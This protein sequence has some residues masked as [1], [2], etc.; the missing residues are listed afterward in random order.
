[1]ARCL[2][3]LHPAGAVFEIR[4]PKT[5]RGPSRLRPGVYSGYYSDPQAAAVGIGRYTGA[6]AD[7][8]YVTLNQIDP[9]L[10]ARRANRFDYL[11]KGDTTTADTQV[12]RR[13]AFYVD[14]DPIRV[15]DV[16]STE[17]EL[18][19]ALA[20][21]TQLVAYLA[22]EG[23][24]DPRIAG[25]SGNGAGLIWAV[26]EPA[27]AET[28][29][30]FTQA[31]AALAAMFATSTVK[32]DTTVV[33]RARV[34]KLYGTVA[35]KGDHTPERPW[36]RAT[37][38][39]R[40]EAGVV[41]RSQLEALAAHAPAPPA[42]NSAAPAFVFPTSGTRAWSVAAKLTAAGIG[43]TGKIRDYGTVYVLDECLTSTAHTDGASIIE[44]PS[45]MLLYRCQHDSCADKRW[46]DAKAALGL[47]DRPAAALETAKLAEG[48][49]AA[50]TGPAEA[51][52]AALRF[53]T[54]RQ[55]ASATPSTPDWIAKPWAAR[56]AILE[57]DGKIKRSGK[58][59]LLLSLAAEVV[60][61]GQ[62]LGE[63][64]QQTGVVYLTEQSDA[65]FRE[66]LRRAGLLDADDL[67]VLCWADARGLG[68]DVVV[69][70][71]VA[72]AVSV[73]AAL[74]IVDT[75]PQWAGVAGDGENSSGEALR[76][77]APLQ[78]AA[79][80]GLAVI[81]ARHERKSGGDV[82]DSGRGSSAFSGAV[83]T[84]VSLRRPSGDAHAGANVRILECLSRFDEVPETLAVELTASGYV[85]LG[86]APAYA[87]ADAERQILERLSATVD[88]AKTKDVLIAGTGI[89][90]TVVHEVLTALVE[91]KV[92]A[93]VGGG[94]KGDPF[95]YYKIR[96]RSGSP[97]RDAA[98][99]LPSEPRSGS[100]PKSPAAGA[101]R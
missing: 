64:V 101:G 37:A 76:A 67:Q 59:T 3:T 10:L 56:G 41:A 72:F 43:F 42:R 8:F 82:G 85:V 62:F 58:T 29:A 25:R 30:L 55:L 18:A 91:R 14:C 78:A 38:T 83:D 53:R 93:K 39:Y 32:I 99:G 66:G 95:R 52:S 15:A 98:T 21:A 34:V 13:T 74:L 5:H 94:K 20:V 69:A 44:C 26:D 73:G 50:P 36:R 49:P 6:D 16:S 75:L 90:G 92:A 80:T 65:T 47:A 89:K 77:M 88:D 48:A 2:S 27:D 51:P 86:D 60:H 46:A 24:P 17:A 22:D 9:A 70:E 28:D 7:A 61:D 57:L 1:M 96:K 12:T 79:A 81:I 23:W 97:C 19:D 54:A 87:K 4:A 35:A 33:N 11:E 100:R 71:A 63:P 68:W 45:G 84:I 31:M 40:P